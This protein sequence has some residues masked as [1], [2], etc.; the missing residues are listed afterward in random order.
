MNKP[1]PSLKKFLFEV[2]TPYPQ[3]LIQLS[4][5]YT[6]MWQMQAGE[7]LPSQQHI[8]ESS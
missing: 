6:R 5:H 2:I 7:F 4:G 1:F 3:A 8:G